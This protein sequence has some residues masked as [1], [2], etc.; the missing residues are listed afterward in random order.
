MPEA[1][2]SVR[3]SSGSIQNQAPR[4]AS[5]VELRVGRVRRIASGVAT[6]PMHRA[7]LLDCRLFDQYSNIKLLGNVSTVHTSPRKGERVLMTPFVTKN[8]T[9]IPVTI[10]SSSL[11]ARS[12][13]IID[14]CL[15]FYSQ[16]DYQV[17]LRSTPI[18]IPMYHNQVTRDRHRSQRICGHHATLRP[19]T[20]HTGCS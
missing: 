9:T 5:L 8:C 6:S 18:I 17:L 13:I 20:S 4:H 14:A 7:G 3:L 16:D 15:P 11:Q 1:M 19:P 12:S 2:Q 10:W